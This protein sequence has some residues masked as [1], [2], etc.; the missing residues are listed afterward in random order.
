MTV[1]PHTVQAQ[2]TGDHDVWSTLTHSGLTQNSSDLLLSHGTSIPGTWNMIGILDARPDPLTDLINPPPL[3]MEN[4]SEMGTKILKL[5]SP[6]SRNLLGRPVTSF[7]VTP[8]IIFR[9]IKARA[10]A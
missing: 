8:L 6:I 1:I 5:L 9:E 10:R 7:A 4:P 3:D 2:L